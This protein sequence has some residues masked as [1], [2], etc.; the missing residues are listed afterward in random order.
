MS[1]DQIMENLQDI[2]REVFDD[3]EMLLSEEMT[4]DDIEEWDSLTHLRLIMQVEKAFSIK[5]STTQIKGLTSVGSFVDA[6]ESEL[7]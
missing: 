6:I 7:Q 5:F 2:Y 1:R 3:E 4:E